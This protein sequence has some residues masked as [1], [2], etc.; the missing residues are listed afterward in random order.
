MRRLNTVYFIFIIGIFYFLLEY[1]LLYMLF[2]KKVWK[3]ITTFNTYLII[4]RVIEKKIY[5]AHKIN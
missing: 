3:G 1:Y 5:K 4:R 2:Q